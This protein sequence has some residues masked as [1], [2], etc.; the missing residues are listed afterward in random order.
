MDAYH[1][2]LAGVAVGLAGM[3]IFLVAQWLKAHDAQIHAEAKVA[4]DQ[5]AF[6]KLSSQQKDLN[7]QLAQVRK[8]Q[9]D[10]NANLAKQFNQAQ[11]PQQMA[12]LIGQMMGLKQAPVVVMPAATPQNPNP[13]PTLELPAA[14]AA[15]FVQDC[16]ECKINYAAA[17]KALAVADKDKS[18]AEEK[19]KLVT[20]QRDELQK[21]VKGGT[22]IT[23]AGKRI[24][25]FVVDA[26]VTALVL[27]GSGHCR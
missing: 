7:D 13:Q 3:G 9:A 25:H 11:T 5:A 24:G 4:A 16:E 8:D 10:Q 6:D 20:D 14:P 22:W 21:A 19:L 2:L 17:Q 23:R 18:L 15:K 26:G 1:K 27:C 12:A